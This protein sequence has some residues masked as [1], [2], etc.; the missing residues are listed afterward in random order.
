MGRAQIGQDARETAPAFTAAADAGRRT[1]TTYRVA[2]LTIAS[3]P[4]LC[5]V[6]ALSRRIATL[7][8]DMPFAVQ[9]NALLEIGRERLS[10][11]LVRIGAKRA[12]LRSNNEIDIAAILADP[13]LLASAGRRALPRVAVDTRARIDIGAHRVTA[14]VRDISTDGIKIFTEELLSIGDEVRVVLKGLERPLPGVVRWCSGDY[15]GVEFVQRLPIGRLN[16]WLAL[17][18]A[19][20]P[21][22][23]PWSPP[24][25]SKS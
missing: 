1:V 13:S 24:I 3:G 20:E 16:A 9:D 22:E 15:A 21:D 5:L 18:S 19:P 23:V 14:Q 4:I 7:D 25:V 10:G 8:I 17:Q 11:A 6:R 2:M 12:E